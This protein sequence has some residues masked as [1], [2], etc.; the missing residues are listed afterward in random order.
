MV[1]DD[2]RVYMPRTRPWNAPEWHHRAFTTSDAIKMDVYSFGMLCL[3]FLFKDT[4]GYPTHSH[5]DEL[6]L[7]DTLPVLAQQLVLKTP[8]LSERQRSNLN[9]FFNVTIVR[10]PNG[11]IKDFR[12]LVQLLSQNR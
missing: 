9:S 3:W 1:A 11:R 5:I 4:E 10:D 8:G 2:D 6:K 12:Q 7:N